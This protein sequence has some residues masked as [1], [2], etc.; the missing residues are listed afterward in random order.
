MSEIKKFPLNQVLIVLTGRLLGKMSEVYEILNYMTGDKIYTHQI[1]RALEAA[2]PAIL[3]QYPILANVDENDYE[4][5]NWKEWL[6]KQYSLFPSE[7]E[8]IP[9]NNWE[10]RDP[11]QELAE[12]VGEEKVI[13][14]VIP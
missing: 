6:D 13:P 10:S 8:L 12:M 5:E 4:A 3:A 9:L 11:I 7:Y 1:G 14:V 2:K